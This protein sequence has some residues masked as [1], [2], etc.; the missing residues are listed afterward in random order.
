MRLTTWVDR[1]TS[2][3]ATP[4]HISSHGISNHTFLTLGHPILVPSSQKRLSGLQ[5]SETWSGNFSTTHVRRMGYKKNKEKA[6]KGIKVASGNLFKLLSSHKL[7]NS[8]EP[9]PT[10]ATVAPSR[11]LNRKFLSLKL[12]SL[13]EEKGAK[14][15][16][17]FPE[18]SEGS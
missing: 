13:Q 11:L 18:G 14:D 8:P 17:R 10:V 12:P 4:E 7:N 1:D 9:R 3:K 2:M 16:Q 6:E 15:F 5:N